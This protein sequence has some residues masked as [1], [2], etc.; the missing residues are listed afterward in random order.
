LRERTVFILLNF[1][2]FF[3][4]PEI[5]DFARAVGIDVD[6]GALV[7]ADLANLICS[8]IHVEKKGPQ[9]QQQELTPTKARKV[10]MAS[11]KDTGLTPSEEGFLFS[12]SCF[13]MC[14]LFDLLRC[15]VRCDSD[16]L[17][18]LL[19]HEM[20]SKVVRFQQQEWRSVVS[21]V[22]LETGVRNGKSGSVFV[23]CCAETRRRATA[24][25]AARCSSSLGRAIGASART[26][27]TRSNFSRF[28]VQIGR[29]DSVAESGACG[30]FGKDPDRKDAVGSASASAEAVEQ[31]KA[32]VA[33]V[34]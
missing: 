16:L 10:F 11:R 9:V 29:S 15:N 8:R 7:K 19:P 18:R 28:G 2:F 26:R 23:V 20:P 12:D 6:R 22:S 4:K 32:A 30:E 13:L 33:L 5:L 34:F 1:F 24:A 27:A 3:E 25:R 21:S 14:R 17:R 31:C